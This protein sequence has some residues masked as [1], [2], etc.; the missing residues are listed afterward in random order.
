MCANL[1]RIWRPSKIIVCVM[2]SETEKD[3]NTT[4]SAS[5]T[6]Q[7]SVCMLDFNAHECTDSTRLFEI[8]ASSK[9]T[10][11]HGIDFQSFIQTSH[12]IS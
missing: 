9:R 6:P 12:K 7:V 3:S 8:A 2:Q 5:Q 1:P 4:M 11:Q 10:C